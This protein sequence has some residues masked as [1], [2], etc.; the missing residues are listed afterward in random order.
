M[1]STQ[2][3]SLAGVCHLFN[4]VPIWGLIAAGGI[5]YA[6]RE[7]SRFVVRH[8]LQAMVFHAMLLVAGLVWLVLQ[9]LCRLLQAISPALS[10]VLYGINDTIIQVLYVLYVGTCLL[11][12][13]RAFSGRPFRYPLVKIR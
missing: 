4:V 13:F 11:G 1:R 12:C 10:N 5:W 2:E 8:A 9:L 6:V 3:H 7:E